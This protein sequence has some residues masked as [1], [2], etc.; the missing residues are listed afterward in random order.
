[1][2]KSSQIRT[3]RHCVFNL[4][5]HLVFLP[6]YRR[7]VFTPRVLDYLEDVMQSICGNFETVLVEFNGEEDHIHILI[8]YP[9]KVSLSKLVNSLKGVSSR[10]VRNQNFKEI[11]DKLWGNHFWSP[12]YYAGSCG[13]VT[14]QQIRKYIENQDRPSIL[15]LKDEVLRA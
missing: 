8:D 15:D 11:E 6:K 10:L 3:G 13:G 12:S 4:K 9:P 5:A 14:V 1:M 2:D 7:S